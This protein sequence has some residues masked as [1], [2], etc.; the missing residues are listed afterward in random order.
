MNRKHCQK[1]ISYARFDKCIGK[2]LVIIKFLRFEQLQNKKNY[3]KKVCFI[4][5]PGAAAFETT[6]DSIT[7]L[8]LYNHYIVLHTINTTLVVPIT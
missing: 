7:N 6:L 2:Y 3:E 4:V 1:S 5:C 8:V